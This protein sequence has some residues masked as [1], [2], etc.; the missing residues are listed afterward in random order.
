VQVCDACVF[1]VHVRTNK[2]V[3]IISAHPHTVGRC[4]GSRAKQRAQK[5]LQSSET[6]SGVF[7]HESRI[8]TWY[9]P[10]QP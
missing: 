1:N 7:G 10:I 6:H 9:L 2:L 4:M 3:G 8:A 5:A